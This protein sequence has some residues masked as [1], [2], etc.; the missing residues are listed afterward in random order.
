M[1]KIDFKS[2]TPQIIELNLFSVLDILIYSLLFIFQISESTGI[3]GGM[4]FRIQRTN[5]ALFKKAEKSLQ[6]EVD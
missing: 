4:H 2:S 1:T 6:N 3:L 5:G